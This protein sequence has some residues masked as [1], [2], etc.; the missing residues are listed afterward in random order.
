MPSANLGNIYIRMFS[1]NNVQKNVHFFSKKKSQVLHDEK[2]IRCRAQL[3]C[4]GSFAFSVNCS[5]RSYISADDDSG[6]SIS[7]EIGNIRNAE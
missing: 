1:K 3:F 6:R 4:I 7:E 5:A 2:P